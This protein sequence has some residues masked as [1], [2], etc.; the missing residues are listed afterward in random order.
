LG[1]V[2]IHSIRT[3]AGLQVILK[4]ITVSFEPDQAYTEG[5]VHL[6]LLDFRDDVARQEPVQYKTE[7]E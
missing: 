1:F 7:K 5:E 2:K 4:K 6:I 3:L